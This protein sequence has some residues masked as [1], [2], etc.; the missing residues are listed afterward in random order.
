[1]KCKDCKWFDDKEN[2]LAPDID[3]HFGECR[4]YAPKYIWSNASPKEFDSVYSDPCGAVWPYVD[5][6]D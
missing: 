4:R 3:K 2:P 6:L 5:A 1:M